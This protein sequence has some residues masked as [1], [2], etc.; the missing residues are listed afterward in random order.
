VIYVAGADPYVDD[1]LGGLSLTFD[2]LE[3]RD[4]R[5]LEGC[6]ERG[7]PVAVTLAGGYARRLEDT[8]RIQTQTCRIALKISGAVPASSRG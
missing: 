7:V 3:A 4:R 6:A 5:V 8:V 2:G 1:Q